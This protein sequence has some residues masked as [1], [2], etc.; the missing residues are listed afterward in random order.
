V[1]STLW[2][3][4]LGSTRTSGTGIPSA[5]SR[6]SMLVTGNVPRFLGLMHGINACDFSALLTYP[7]SKIVREFATG[8]LPA[9]ATGCYC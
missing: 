4:R 5:Y 3:M 1:S 9:I 2:F 6:Y 7:M 8:S